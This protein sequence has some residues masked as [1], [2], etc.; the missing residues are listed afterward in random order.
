MGNATLAP[1]AAQ[2][3]TLSLP[4]MHKQFSAA[5]Q[6]GVLPPHIK[7]VEQA[8]A[9]AVK[10]QEMGFKPYQALEAIIP[11][12][13]RYTVGPEALLSLA[14][15]KVRGFVCEVVKSDTV[16][17]IVKMGRDGKVTFTSAYTMEDAKRAGLA[18]KDNYRKNG[19][20]MLRWRALG[21][22]LKIV[23]PDI[24]RGLPTPE[25]AEEEEVAGRMASVAKADELDAALSDASSSPA[26]D[27]TFAPPTDDLPMPPETTP[28]ADGTVDAA[29]WRRDVLAAFAEFK[30]A[31]TPAEFDAVKA[32]AKIVGKTPPQL[33]PTDIDAIN[34]AMPSPFKIVF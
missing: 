30:K 19:P 13:G 2:P 28:D 32:T 11:I 21:A 15:E 23:C 22:G 6:A 5:L 16:G 4:E 25:E 1:V 12:Q 31:A 8:I 3:S 26:I 29:T 24:R 9:I 18:D 34:D 17:A 14:Y 27:T 33:T 7:S 10:G 20:A